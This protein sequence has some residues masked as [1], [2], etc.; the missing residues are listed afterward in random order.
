[1]I[2]KQASSRLDLFVINKNF[3]SLWK[4]FGS[5]WAFLFCIFGLLVHSPL[6]NEKETIL[7]L[8]SFW[9]FVPIDEI[10]LADIA[11]TSLF[12]ETRKEE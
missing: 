3:S 1:M 5:R 7:F 4:L 8:F 12:P 2:N 10:T 11:E 9:M 6:F